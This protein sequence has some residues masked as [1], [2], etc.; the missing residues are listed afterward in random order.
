MAEGHQTAHTR[1]LYILVKSC[2]TKLYSM[3]YCIDF[4]GQGPL[5]DKNGMCVPHEANKDEVISQTAM[6][7][8]ILIVSPLLI[9]LKI[10]LTCFNCW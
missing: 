1:I 9:A 10:I 3:Q 5:R 7:I 2:Q 4:Y 8:S 6:L